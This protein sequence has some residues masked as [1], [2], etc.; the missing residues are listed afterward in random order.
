MCQLYRNDLCSSFLELVLHTESQKFKL[1]RVKQCY[2]NG[3]IL[4]VQSAVTTK[5]FLLTEAIKL[6]ETKDH[7]FLMH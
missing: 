6:S 4:E 5:Y 3:Q 1:I 7:I 2:A